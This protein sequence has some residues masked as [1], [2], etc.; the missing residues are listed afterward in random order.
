MYFPKTGKT[1]NTTSACINHIRKNYTSVSEAYLDVHQL[2]SVPKCLYCES[3]ANFISINKGFHIHCG[4]KICKKL[5]HSVK[6]RRVKNVDPNYTRFIIGNLDDYRKYIN[7]DKYYDRFYD[8]IIKN[9]KTFISRHTNTTDFIETKICCITGE[10]F[11]INIL[12]N[13]NEINNFVGSSKR[14]RHYRKFSIHEIMNLLRDKYNY[15]QTDSIEIKANIYNKQANSHFSRYICSDT[16]IINIFNKIK[17]QTTKIIYSIPI[18]MSKIGTKFKITGKIPDEVIENDYPENYRICKVCNSKY[19][20]NYLYYDNKR[21]KFEKI[22]K[23]A[24]HTCSENC[25]KLILEEKKEYYEYKEETKQK[26]SESIKQKILSGEW[27][28]NVTNSWCKSRVKILDINFRSTWEAAFYLYNYSNGIEMFYEKIRVKY[29][30]GEKYRNYIIDFVDEN[31]RILYE[32]KPDAFVE[33]K[34]IKIKEAAAISWC[35]KNGYKFEFINENYFRKIITEEFLAQLAQL[36]GI[37]KEIIFSRLGQFL[38]KT[39]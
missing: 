37:K 17:S 4:S 2:D 32:I 20:Y 34:I 3:P 21:K 11:K 29:F 5:N 25:Y 8:K 38:T 30:N 14:S 39:I 31:N 15:D 35:N 26:Q 36:S 19:V 16:N 28:P 22:K 27:T 1:F 10:E 33:D 23:G 24:E 6:N 18:E 7:C 9:P 13:D 12:L